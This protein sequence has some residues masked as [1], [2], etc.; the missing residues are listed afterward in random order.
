[1]VSS[2]RNTEVRRRDSS[3]KTVVPVRYPRSALI[4]T[5]LS[6]SIWQA[7]TSP[8][9]RRRRT[10]DWVRR[11]RRRSWLTSPVCG[12]AMDSCQ[13]WSYRPDGPARPAPGAARS[14]LISSSIDSTLS[15]FST[16]SPSDTDSPSPIGSPRLRPKPEFG[17]FANRASAGRPLSR[18]SILPV[19]TQPLVPSRSGTTRC[20]LGVSACASLAPPELGPGDLP[21][22][23]VT[24][25]PS[26]RPCTGHR[27]DR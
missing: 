17:G 18:C 26:T 5:R 14:P 7:T 22:L 6:N 1:M 4:S 24:N 10:K 20:E 3:P 2:A 11:S 16:V 9:C 21:S 19:P 13:S 15:A 27:S 8:P 12:S 25:R 23:V